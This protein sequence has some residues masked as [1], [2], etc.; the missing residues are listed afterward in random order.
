MLNTLLDMLGSC[1]APLMRL[2]QRSWPEWALTYL[3]IFR[4]VV[5]SSCLLLAGVAWLTHIHW[6]LMASIC[7]AIGEF[8]EST[9]YIIVLK[10]GD[11]SGRISPPA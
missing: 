5:V 2:R 4:A 10:W 7:I 1:A 8:L 11:R 6:L 3:Y 9:Y